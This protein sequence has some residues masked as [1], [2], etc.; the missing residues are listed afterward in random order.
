MREP[1]LR[2]LFEFDNSW[3]SNDEAKGDRNNIILLIFLFFLGMQLEQ[4]Q[5]GSH[6]MNDVSLSMP[7][8]MRCGRVQLK[9]GHGILFSI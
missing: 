7:L 8:N 4:M 1:C 5:I 6:E 3:T 9:A 2:V